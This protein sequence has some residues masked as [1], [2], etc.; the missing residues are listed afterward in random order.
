MLVVCRKP[1]FFL[2]CELP[3]QVDIAAYLSGQLHPCQFRSVAKLP[4]V[5]QAECYAHFTRGLGGNV[6]TDIREFGFGYWSPH[7]YL[8]KRR[9]GGLTN[10][11]TTSA[12]KP[13]KQNYL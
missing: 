4:R 13:E 7:N 1:I 10:P 5:F 8:K 2:L 6:L 3:L 12:H 9:T 11:I